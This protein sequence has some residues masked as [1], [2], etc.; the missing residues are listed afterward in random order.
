MNPRPVAFVL[1]G[2][3][4]FGTVGT[5][6]VL[7]PDAPSVAVGALRL[8]LGSAGLMGV[9]LLA[10]GRR[11]FRS[12]LTDRFV[13]LAALGQAAFQV[14]FLSAV[15]VTGVAVG[16]L[17]AIGSAPLITGLVV[18]VLGRRVDGTWLLATAVALAGLTMLVLRGASG[19]AV[20]LGG[21]GL[22]V[23]AGASY[24]TYI[25]ASRDLATRRVPV[26]SAVAGAFLLAGLL[27]APALLVSDLAWVATRDGLATVIYLAVV[28]TA[29]A[30]LLFNRG[31]AGVPANSAATLGLIEPVVA[32]LLGVLVLDERLGAVGTVGALLVLTGLLLL[33]RTTQPQQRAREL[34]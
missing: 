2:A 31:L 23:G 33:V 7:G 11:V 13:W 22:A 24:S 6:R 14:F 20:D 26:N 18:A 27:L 9:A 25:L 10:D 19:A 12:V 21:A 15:E 34:G 17:V 28:P 4:L 32:A 3:A 29:L 8:M 1:A 16:T 5:A 30:Y